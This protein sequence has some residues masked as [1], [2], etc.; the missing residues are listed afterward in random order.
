MAASDKIVLAQPV[1]NVVG[2]SD[3]T[4]LVIGDLTEG[5][6]KI[7]SEVIEKAK[8]GKLDFEYGTIEEEFSFTFNAIPGD[9]GQASLKRAIQNKL[10]VK[11][12]IIDRVFDP[13]TQKHKAIFAYTVIEEYEGSFD[14]EE[15]TIEIT[16]KVKITSVEMDFP[17][18][19]ESILNPST[20]A[21]VAA[22]LPYE[23][24]GALEVRTNTPAGA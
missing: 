4:D 12:W 15:S 21:S 17:K 13:E 7:A 5:S 3:F 9:K 22:E 20:A 2:G 6:H 10:Q 1:D 18:L 24:T 19:P 23:Y 8:A 14:D 16:A 11:I